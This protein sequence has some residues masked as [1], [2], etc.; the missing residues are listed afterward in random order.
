MTNKDEKK[1]LLSIKIIPLILFTIITILGIIIAIYINK[2]NFNNEIKK[3]K[4]IY[5]KNEKQI[6]KNEVLKIQTIF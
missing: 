4:D 3:V 5:L 2:I 1:L 6:I